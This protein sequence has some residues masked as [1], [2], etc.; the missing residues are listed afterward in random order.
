MEHIMAAITCINSIK[1]EHRTDKEDR[2]LEDTRTNLA[3]EWRVLN[4]FADAR[5]REEQ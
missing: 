3:E 1:W 4:I 2:F 5:K